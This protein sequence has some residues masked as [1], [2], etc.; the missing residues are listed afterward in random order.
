MAGPIRIAVLADGSA[1][2]KSMKQF[3]DDVDGN[4]RRAA[5]SVGRSGQ[6]M[7]AG[8]D[9]AIEGFDTAD[10]RAMG[11]RDTI[12]GLQDTA[13]G[14]SKLAKG[15]LAGGLLTLG[16]GVGDL[17]SGFSNF[18]IPAFAKGI[19]WIKNLTVVQR[20]LNI[21]MLTNPVFLVVAA[22][23]ALV[24]IIVIAY[25]KSETFRAIVQAVWAAIKT[26]ILAVVEWFKGAMTGL[27]SKATQVWEAIKIV[28]RL[29][30]FAITSYINAYKA[31]VTG[32]WN[33]VKNA[34]VTAWNGIKTAISNV[35]T[36]T[37]SIVSGGIDKIKALF[38][39][40]TLYNAGRELITGLANGIGERIGA[41]IQKVRDGVNKIK[42][43]LPG[44][45][46]KWG[47]LTSWNN[48]GAG[49]RL[50]G[51]LEDGIRSG[52]PGVSAA[53]SKGI[54]ADARI[55]IGPAGAA[56][57]PTPPIVITFE[58]SGDPL[59]DA[60]FDQLRKRIRVQG[61]NVQMVLGRA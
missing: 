16:M 39:P 48:G 34:A 30:M 5:G 1:A 52:A 60:I 36:T 50:M 55:G 35:I 32:V 15:D 3:A 45:P 61:G 23:V 42:G 28:V 58:A 13:G 47:P 59:M 17:A 43:L 8:T 38:S 44:S 29:V 10:T 2:S 12:T 37:R 4:V 22:I 27:W 20:I 21:T 31:V 46:I 51:L 25:K 57:E 26:A 7:K 33:A 6:D 11:F 18:L 41:A 49:R 14:F 53:L 9:R 40:T 54:S 24:A 56:A 19:G